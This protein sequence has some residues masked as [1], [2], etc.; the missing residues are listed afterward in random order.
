MVHAIDRAAT[1]TGATYAYK[2]SIIYFIKS[3]IG[4]DIPV[5][6]RGGSYGCERSSLPHFLDKRLT[7][8]GKV[9]SPT[10]RPPFTPVFFLKIPGTRFC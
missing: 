9:V 4:K 10:R 6:G 1:V 7:D 8:G 3:K 5:T 2:F